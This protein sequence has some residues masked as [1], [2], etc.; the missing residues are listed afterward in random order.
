MHRNNVHLT[1]YFLAFRKKVYWPKFKKKLFSLLTL[2]WARNNAGVN[3]VGL[4]CRRRDVDLEDEDKAE[5]EMS[6]A[7]AVPQTP[8]ARDCRDR[9]R[10]LPDDILQCTLH[11]TAVNICN[12]K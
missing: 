10:M 2:L 7:V 5:D 11:C 12:V 3:R 9:S 6:A 4:T 8:E 1:F